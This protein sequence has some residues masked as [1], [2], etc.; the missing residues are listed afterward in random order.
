MEN[1][2]IANRMGFLWAKCVHEVYLKSEDFW[3]YTS[4][5]ESRWY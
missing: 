5:V 1:W 3:H 4:A 2:T